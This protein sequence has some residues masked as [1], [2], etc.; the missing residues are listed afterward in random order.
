MPQTQALTLKTFETKVAGWVP[1]FKQALPVACGIE[2]ERFARVLVTAVQQ[3]PNLLDCTF[4][5]LIGAAMLSAQLGLEPDGVSN[6]AAIVKYGNKAQFQPGYRGL[7]SLAYRSGMVLKI[8][9]RLV[10]RGEEFDVQFG[11]DPQIRHVP[12]LDAQAEED[13]DKVVYAYGVAWLKGGMFLFEPIGRAKMD[14]IASKSRSSAWKDRLAKPAMYRKTATRRLCGRLPTAAGSPLQKAVGW[15]EMAEMGIDQKTEVY[16]TE[17]AEVEFE[18]KSLAGV[19]ERLTVKKGQV[20]MTSEGAM[21]ADNWTCSKCGH[22]HH[23]PIAAAMCEQCGE[24]TTAKD[25]DRAF[26]DFFGE[27]ERVRE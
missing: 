6:M 26:E 27:P 18:D 2:P 21:F 7:E 20:Y 16:A 25:T 17:P 22:Y 23:G 12:N 15:D 4:E 9:S 8:E 3:S 13:P 11:T 19:T 5:S 14:A 24:E 1:R 10:Y